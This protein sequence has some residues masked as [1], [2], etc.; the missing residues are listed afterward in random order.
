MNITDIL[1]SKTHANFNSTK[2]MS[3]EMIAEQDSKI[4]NT[5][6]PTKSGFFKAGSNSVTILTLAK[7]TL[8]AGVLAL[9]KKAM[10]TGI[11]FFLVLLCFG[12]FFTAKSIPMITKGS[13]R[14]G[15]NGFEDITEA[16]FGRNMGIILGVSMLLNCYGASIVYVIAIKDSLTALMSELYTTSGTDW[17]LY[18][19]LIIGGL[20]LVPLSIVE[21]LNSLRILSMAGVFGVFFTVGSVIYALAL[22]GIASDLT[23]ST[24]SA[25]E[26]LM[27]PQGGFVD[28]MTVICAITF[29]FCNQYNVPQ[30][31]GEM[32]NRTP[33]AS[34][35]VAN[36][37]TL[38]AMSLYVV[39]GI[40]G[41]LCYG[42]AIDS[43]IL[44][45]FIPL[46]EAGYIFIYIGVIAVTW[47][48]TMC[49]LL[50]NFP[51]RLSVL[52][53]LPA[54]FESNKWIKW[55][56][57]LF[58]AISTIAIGLS[59]P[60]LNVILG[61]VGSLTGSIICYIVPGLISI[62]ASQL[63]A[64]DNAVENG[65]KDKINWTQSAYNHP[66]EYMMIAVGTV[67]GIVGTFC[68]FYSC[69]NAA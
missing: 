53:F 23:T 8:G 15:K 12:A 39:T 42:L 26:T 69:F 68:E 59:Y 20:I 31:Y 4:E 65:L 11:P 25:T 58:T 29:A 40:C 46:I 44:T 51:M 41:Y 2:K 48:V 43:D 17:P 10:Y 63:D 27:S 30:L 38:L 64:R 1:S 62:R 3:T 6:Q 56:V 24:S 33:A 37:S 32:T 50:N 7:G 13:D 52:F 14:T 28:I 67:I 19:T 9:S 57:P 34:K 55:G 54:R 45:N 61:L 22:T 5:Q 60:Y 21:K 35:Y 16:L 49:H 36:V 47:S 66:I 18:A